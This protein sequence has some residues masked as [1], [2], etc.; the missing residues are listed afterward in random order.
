MD[1]LKYKDLAAAK[2]MIIVPTGDP[3]AQLQADPR[4]YLIDKMIKDQN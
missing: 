1:D 3:P 2:N 4:L